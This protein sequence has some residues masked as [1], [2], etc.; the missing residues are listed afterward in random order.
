MRPSSF[1]SCDGPC[2]QAAPHRGIQP[3]RRVTQPAWRK[4]AAAS[5]EPFSNQTS[6]LFHCNHSLIVVTIVVLIFSNIV[7]KLN[8][9]NEQQWCTVR[10]FVL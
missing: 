8:C 4:V 2:G 6:A 1:V 3:A 9:H 10:M 7:V 5:G